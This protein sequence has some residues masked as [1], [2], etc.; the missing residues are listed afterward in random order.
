MGRGR[1]VIM[2]RL[3]K[4]HVPWVKTKNLEKWRKKHELRLSGPYRTKI[5]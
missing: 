1:I 4:L 5:A 3:P 2:G